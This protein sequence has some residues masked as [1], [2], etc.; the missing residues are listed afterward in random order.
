MV[1]DV[2]SSYRTPAP[3]GG[4]DNIVNFADAF[5]GEDLGVKNLTFEGE[6]GNDEVEGEDG[7]IEDEEQIKLRVVISN[8]LSFTVVISRRQ[9][10]K[11]T[12]NNTRRYN[13]KR[14]V[15]KIR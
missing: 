12:N 15:K 1:L 8:N 11:K 9:G 5:Q 7:V 10:S 2:S 6:D 4:G 13:L 3:S 14:L